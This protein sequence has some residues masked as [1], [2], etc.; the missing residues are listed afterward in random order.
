MPEG[1][2]VVDSPV[3]PGEPEGLVGTLRAQGGD[4]C[5]LLVTHA[6]WDHL[7][8]PPA[9]PGV[10][11][12]LERRTAARLEAE[13]PAIAAELAAFDRGE[14]RAARGLPRP[15]HVR[16]VEA[17]DTF[18]VGGGTVEVHPVPGHTADGAAWL[19]PDAGVLCPGD[20][21]SPVEEPLVAAGGS[22]E[23]YGRALD[24]LEGLLARVRV[25]VP[26]HGERL[27]PAGAREVLE[28]DRRLLRRPG[29]ARSTAGA[30]P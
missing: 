6:D 15:A 7:L 17:P 3:E 26:G 24:L 16:V 22:V 19:F 28:R 8:M 20:Y 30:D 2:V 10:E 9:L 13:G 25:V 23:D 11:V 12:V 29:R 1:W 27:T 21:L 4:V 18:T 5:A 14:G